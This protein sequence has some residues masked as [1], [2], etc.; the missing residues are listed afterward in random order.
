MPDVRLRRNP[1]FRLLGRY[2]PVVFDSG[3]RPETHV[4]ERRESAMT[5]VTD[6]GGTPGLSTYV[7]CFVTV[8]FKLIQKIPGFQMERCGK[9]KTKR[10]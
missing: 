3:L 6:G 4:D 8:G 5:V 7:G 9:H 2:A 10:F 1:E